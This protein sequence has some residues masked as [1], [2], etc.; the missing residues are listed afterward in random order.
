[1]YFGCCNDIN[2]APRY[3]SAAT[4]YPPRTSHL[5]VVHDSPDFGDGG[6]FYSQDE[7][8][9]TPPP[10]KSRTAELGPR[11]SP[12]KNK[13]MKGASTD[14][15]SGGYGYRLWVSPCVRHSP[16]VVAAVH[17]EYNINFFQ[18]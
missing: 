17:T 2:A 4:Y 18:H 15:E 16:S 11:V 6:G 10:K 7:E 12:R 3:P 1:M 14:V 8:Q 5:P 9:A 13:G